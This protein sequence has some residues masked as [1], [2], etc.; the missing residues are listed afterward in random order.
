MAVAGIAA[1]SAIDSPTRSAM[2]PRL[3]DKGQ[4][5]AAAALNQIIWNGAGLIGPALAGVVVAGF[6]FSWAYAIDLIS[7]GLLLLASIS[8]RPM[9]PSEGERAA[10]G[11]RAVKEGFAFLRGRQVLQSTFVIDIIAMVFGMPRAL[12]PVLAI[13]QFH[14]GATVVGLLFA[15][16]AV[17]AFI[18][19][20]DERLGRPDP[21]P[22]AGGDLGGRRVGRRHRGVRAGRRA[23]VA[24][25]VRSSRSRARPT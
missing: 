15:A 6:G 16:P 7:I 4:L 3:L 24:R 22:G 18:G 1:T 20:G 23:P 9:P 19:R 12:F 21:S 10:V 11:W 13:T 17:G 5:P 8:I 2:T 14:R 25:A